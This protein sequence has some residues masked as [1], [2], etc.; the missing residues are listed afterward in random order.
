[1]LITA[2]CVPGHIKS[3]RNDT[4]ARTNISR[5]SSLS[6]PMRFAVS[7]I[8][9]KFAGGELGRRYGR[10]I[11]KRMNSRGIARP[12]SSSPR[13][14]VTSK[15]MPGAGRGFLYSHALSSRS[16]PWASAA[17]ASFVILSRPSTLT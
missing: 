4:G 17:A 9:F 5:Y 7:C 13:S 12:S 6:G 15:A 3:P 16:P 10:V 14:L 1:M 8:G 2:A 11:S